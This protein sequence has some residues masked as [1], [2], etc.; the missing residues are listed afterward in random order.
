MPRLRP[1]P[2][3]ERAVAK[4]AG[5]KYDGQT[6]PALCLR[7]QHVLVACVNGTARQLPPLRFAADWVVWGW[8]FPHYAIAIDPP[9]VPPD[10]Q[11]AKMAWADEHGVLY[12]ACHTNTDEPGRLDIRKL[13]RVAT[14]WIKE[15]RGDAARAA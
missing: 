3:L 14:E 12:F 6:L 13:E 10:E 11:A 9:G 4:A 8:W 2:P 1:V 7:S 15:L 5:Q